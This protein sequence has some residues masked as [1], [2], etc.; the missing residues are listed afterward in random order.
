M[1]EKALV[2]SMPQ[3]VLLMLK[4]G[5]MKSEGITEAV[6]ISMRSGAWKSGYYGY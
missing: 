1:A 4:T 2:F 3:E 6:T 5:N